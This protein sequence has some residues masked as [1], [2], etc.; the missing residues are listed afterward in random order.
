MVIL[1]P[2]VNA[3]PNTAF[4]GKPNEL[5]YHRT[6]GSSQIVT[7]ELDT[8]Y[9]ESGGIGVLKN[10]APNTESRVKPHLAQNPPDSKSVNPLLPPKH[11]FGTMPAHDVIMFS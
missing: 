3:G 6:R 4:G 5:G 7:L 11:R 2:G 9:V 8:F 10:V 1:L